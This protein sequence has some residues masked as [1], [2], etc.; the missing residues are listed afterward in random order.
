[1]T[2]NS[3][4]SPRIIEI[5]DYLFLREKFSDTY[6]ALP[7]S[8]RTNCYIV[9][10]G[11]EKFLV[12]RCNNEGKTGNITGYKNCNISGVSSY[13]VFEIRD[14]NSLSEFCSFDFKYSMFPIIPN[15]KY[16]GLCAVQEVANITFS[17]GKSVQCKRNQSVSDVLFKTFILSDDWNNR[18][19][20]VN[21]HGRQY[22]FTDSKVRYFSYL[23]SRAEMKENYKHFLI[24]RDKE[25][26]LISAVNKELFR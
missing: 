7:L 18:R 24:P 12:V 2:F 22:V 20:I 11:K 17:E 4:F 23:G 8:Y 6:E 21:I 10:K 15:N 26:K 9:A 19:G 16:S 3:H 1:M 25:Q 14:D 13:E 5:E